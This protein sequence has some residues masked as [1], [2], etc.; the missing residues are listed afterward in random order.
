M[1]VALINPGKSP[2]FSI[3]E[4]LN[5]AFIAAYLEKNNI[6]IKIIDELA[7]E[8]V[9]QALDKFKPDIAGITATTPLI[10]DAYRNA[11]ICKNKGILTVIGGVH[12]SI[13]PEEALR[14]ADIVVKQ[15]GELAMLNIIHGNIKSGVVTAPYIKNIDE[16]PMPARHLLN[17]DFYLKS[18]DRVAYILYYTFIP[19]RVKVATLLTSRGCPYHCIFCHNTW[20]DTPCRFNSAE[21]VVAEIKELISRYGVAAGYFVEDNFFLEKNR[22]QRI[23]EMIIAK[24]IK[25]I[26]GANT[27][28]DNIDAD[29]L[30][31]A[32]R[33]GCRLVSFG[34]ESGSQR[35]LNL[36]KKGV[37]IEQSRRAIRICNDLGLMV[38]GSFI[39]GNPTETLE[40]IKQTRDF[41]KNNNITTPG[42]YISTPYPGTGLWEMAKD[43]DPALKDG[44][45]DWSNF[46]QERVTVNLSHIAKET[47][48]KLRARLYLE[49]FFRHKKQALSLI[50]KSLRYPRAP[51]E[52]IA[53]T[54]KPLLN[55]FSSARRKA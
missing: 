15:E 41:I 42:I 2:R 46:A 25:F 38:N 27:R 37:T 53:I 17:M 19:Y 1:K 26:W 39:I 4:P 51:F 36:L 50:L 55:I 22:A 32:R 31:L 7:G 54:L 13:Y 6:K 35:I 47:V 28:V 5:L 10:L 11:Q 45:V 24:N 21:R 23:C 52:K 16:I 12:A 49:Y 33:A 29:T 44:N 48:E 3:H 20:R 8:D 34:F 18:R 43:K 9:K 30:K 40:D 14:Y